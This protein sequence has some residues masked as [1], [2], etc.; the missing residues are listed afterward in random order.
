MKINDQLNNIS[1]IKQLFYILTQIFK[2]KKKKKEKKGKKAAI[3][4]LGTFSPTNRIF[5]YF[6]I[7]F[8]ILLARKNLHLFISIL[9]RF[10]VWESHVSLRERPF[11]F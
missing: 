5:L 1:N 11:N 4:T 3:I 9:F 7:Y 2:K 10:H 6:K 8:K